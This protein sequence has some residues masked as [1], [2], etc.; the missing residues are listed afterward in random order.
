M[1]LNTIYRE[2]NGSL[3]GRRKEGVR[4]REKSEFQRISHEMEEL[5]A[6]MRVREV[7]ILM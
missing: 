5:G 4:E 1:K 2:R 3:P 7:N 6:Q